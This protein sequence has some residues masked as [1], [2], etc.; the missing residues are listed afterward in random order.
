MLPKDPVI[1]LSYVNMKL[2]DGCGGLEELCA[3]EGAELEELTARL[4]AA[5]FYY[6]PEQNQFKV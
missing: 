6:D 4:S 5:G 1:L 3:L 2:R